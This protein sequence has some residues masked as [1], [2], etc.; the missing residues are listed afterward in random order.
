MLR[1]PQARVVPFQTLT[2]IA[3]K[4]S[5]TNRKPTAFLVPAKQQELTNTWSKAAEQQGTIL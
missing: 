4:A 3:L 5:N 2:L 1:L